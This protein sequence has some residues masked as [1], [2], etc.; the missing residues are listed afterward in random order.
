MILSFHAQILMQ[1]RS[2]IPLYFVSHLSVFT[3]KTHRTWS[4]SIYNQTNWRPRF[5]WVVLPKGGMVTDGAED[6]AR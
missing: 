5:I 4:S 3:E 2:P 1:R 6:I